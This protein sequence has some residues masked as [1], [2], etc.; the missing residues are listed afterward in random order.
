MG[1]ANG[2]L[3]GGPS[4]G[5]QETAAGGVSPQQNALAQYQWGQGIASNADK[6]STSGTPMSTGL[7]QTDAGTYAQNA[8]SL[9]EMSQKNAEAEANLIDQYNKERQGNTA[10][11]V[12]AL[13]GAAGSK[14]G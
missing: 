7:T 13:S 11:I 9:S 5:A 2:I 14:A 3:S 10:Q 6:F 4:Q 8:L 1:G 12:G